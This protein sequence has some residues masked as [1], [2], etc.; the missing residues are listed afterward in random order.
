MGKKRKTKRQWLWEFIKK[1]VIIETYIYVAS[2]TYSAVMIWFYP[3]STA[4]VPFMDNSTKVFLVTVV[5]YAV[6][7][8]FENVTKIKNNPRSE[9]TEEFYRTEGMDNE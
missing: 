9:D 5:C 7:A 2:M 1:I 8:G 6:K 4:I 3:D